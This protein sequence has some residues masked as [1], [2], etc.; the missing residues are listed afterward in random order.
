M[1]APVCSLT[2]YAPYFYQTGYSR[3]F[4]EY[5]LDALGYEI[6]S[7][8]SNGNYFEY[9]GQEIRRLAMMAKRYAGDGLRWHER[10]ARNVLLAGL[11]RWSREDEGSSEMLAFGI[12]VV[13]QKAGE[14]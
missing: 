2:H 7:M 9:I 4:Y 13:A 3:Y 1:S 5:W 6:L 12:H 8:E 14:S 10:I 11:R